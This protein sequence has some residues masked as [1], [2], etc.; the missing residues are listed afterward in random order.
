MNAWFTEP[1]RS[2]RRIRPCGP[3]AL[4]ALKFLAYARRIP[5]LIRTGEYTH[6]F[7]NAKVARI[8]DRIEAHR[9]DARPMLE[10]SRVALFGV[11]DGRRSGDNEGCGGA[12]DAVRH[13]L[14]QLVP[15]QAWQPTVDLGTSEQAP[16]RTTPTLPFSRS[17]PSLYKWESFQ[18]FSEADMT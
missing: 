7:S 12:P 5:R 18:S 15:P 16:L 11:N 2:G 4:V 17:S 10:G 1:V 13:W 9:F 6:D 3:S 8:A 14:Y